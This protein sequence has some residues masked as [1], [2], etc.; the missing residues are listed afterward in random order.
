MKTANLEMI[1][2][3]IRQK[4]NNVGRA[5]RDVSYS[6]F[7]GAAC[8]DCGHF[9][10]KSKGYKTREGNY[11]HQSGCLTEYVNSVA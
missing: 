6:F 2:K 11:V 7:G 9:V 3:A 4:E 5:I 10:S 1:V 8:C